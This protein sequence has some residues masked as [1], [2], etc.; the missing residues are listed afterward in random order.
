MAKVYEFTDGKERYLKLADRKA[1]KGDL[2]GALSMLNCAL[3]VSGDLSIYGDIADIY[4]DMELYE[5][6]N[7]YWYKYL[8]SMPKEKSG[9]AYEELGINYFCLQ[10]FF[11]FFVV[12]I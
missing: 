5:L 8:D 2:L 7:K 9:T 4:A 10:N 1:E 12:S 3:K 6:S 11:R